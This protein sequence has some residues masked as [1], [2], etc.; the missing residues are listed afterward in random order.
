MKNTS[1]GSINQPMGGTA[2]MFVVLFCRTR[3]LM[4]YKCVVTCSL[5]VEPLHSF[6]G[7]AGSTGHARGINSCTC[8]V[9]FSIEYEDGVVWNAMVRVTKW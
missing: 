2:C 7:T 4:T 6:L 3:H 9:C 8:Q 1:R 5:F